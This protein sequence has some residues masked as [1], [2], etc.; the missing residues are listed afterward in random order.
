MAKYA[1]GLDYGTNSCRS[2]I[3]NL[4]N[5]E[6]VATHV[7]TPFR[8]HGRLCLTLRIPMSPANIRTTI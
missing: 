3:I 7:L 2:L 8:R 5:G 6:E 1:I 4:E